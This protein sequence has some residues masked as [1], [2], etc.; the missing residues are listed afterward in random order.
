MV[1]KTMTNF[2]DVVAFHEKFGVPH[3][4]RPSFLDEG[5]LSFRLKFMQEELDEFA[6][7]AVKEN[8]EDMADA[9]IDLVYVAL[10]T[11]HMMGLPWDKLWDEV[12]R[13]NMSKQRA[14]SAGESKRGTSLDV[15][16][17]AGWTAPNH[18]PALAEFY[19]PP[20]GVYSIGSVQYDLF[21]TS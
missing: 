6:L 4:K 21:E 16:K 5:A 8:M 3:V 15:I 11:A 18:V 10:G 2:Q 12:Q 17:P 19:V 14:S 20:H 1:G 7:G 9:L 13:A